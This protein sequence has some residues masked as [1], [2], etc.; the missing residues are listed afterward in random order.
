MKTSDRSDREIDV[1]HTFAGGG[2]DRAAHLR[3]DEEAVRRLLE[4]P[5]SRVLPFRDLRPLLQGEDRLEPAWR[6]LESLRDLEADVDTV[7]LGLEEGHGRFAVADST[8]RESGF[9]PDAAAFV[10]V[11]AAASRLGGPDASVVAL[12]RSLLSWNASHRF[13]PSCGSSTESAHAGHQRRCTDAGCGTVQFPRTDPVVIMLIC[14]GERCLLGRS[15]RSPHYPPGLH[16]CLA[17]YVEPGE[18]IEEAVRRESWEEAGLRI[19]GVRYHSSQPWPFPSSLMIGCFAE[20]L[21][22]RVRPDPREL[23]SLRWFTLA[24]LGEAVRGW[25]HEG[26]LRLPPPITIAHQLARAWLRERGVPVDGDPGHPPPTGR[27]RRGA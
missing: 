8:D 4:S 20:A 26:A 5:D 9:P 10:A 13:C 24:E 11:R 21:H 6:S 2:L 14:R 1:I 22:D 12:A 7:F 3:G 15:L 19:G 16:S 27:N 23:E 18:S 17:G 25:D